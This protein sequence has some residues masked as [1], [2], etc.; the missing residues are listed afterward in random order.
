VTN[1]LQPPNRWLATR[2]F[3]SALDATLHMQEA[4]EA[5]QR[6]AAPRGEPPK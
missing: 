2:R 1:R 4:I 5:Q 6:G 3:F